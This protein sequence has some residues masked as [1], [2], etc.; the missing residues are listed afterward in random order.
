M[1]LPAVCRCA[2]WRSC[3]RRRF[4]FI[5]SC[6]DGSTHCGIRCSGSAH[7]GNGTKNFCAATEASHHYLP[8]RRW[9]DQRCG[10]LRNRRWKAA[11]RRVGFSG[12]QRGRSNR[13]RC[14]Q[15]GRSAGSCR[16][17]R[18]V[19]LVNNAGRGCRHRPVR[20]RHPGS[21]VSAPASAG[22]RRPRTELVWPGFQSERRWRWWPLP[23]LESPTR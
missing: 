10:R 14:D 7:A 9:P 4:G 19:P 13:P 12:R 17:R 8:D 18:H 11:G 21:R 5:P 3:N 2:S 22:L 16:I 23:T 6:G 1:G 20:D 15:S